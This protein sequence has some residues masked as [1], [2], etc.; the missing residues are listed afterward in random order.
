MT[1]EKQL[2]EM[3]QV[4]YFA[5]IYL[6]QMI[7]RKMAKN[8]IGNIIF[9]S[10]TSGINGDSGRLAYSSSKASILSTVKTLF[11]SKTP[12]LAQVTRL[13]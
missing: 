9:I 8:K 2:Q 5:Q 4:N 13:P 7:S 6:T 10:S 12:W 1:S 11:S 3:F